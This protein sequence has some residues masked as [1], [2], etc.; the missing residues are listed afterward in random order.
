M[1]IFKG[2]CIICVM[3]LSYSVINL[4]SMFV[5]DKYKPNHCVVLMLIKMHLNTIKFNFMCY[6]YAISKCSVVFVFFFFYNM[7]L[8]Y[9]SG[10][11]NFFFYFAPKIHEFIFYAFIMYIYIHIANLFIGSMIINNFKLHHDIQIRM[12]C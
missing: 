2:F 9:D 6:I 8:W 12:W 10:F 1:T 4:W 5:H 7:Q 3:L 11:A